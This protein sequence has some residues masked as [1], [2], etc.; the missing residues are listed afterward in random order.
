MKTCFNLMTCKSCS[1]C[2][3]ENHLDF[4]NENSRIFPHKNDKF[5][6]LFEKEEIMFLGMFNEEIKNKRIDTSVIAKEGIKM[7]SM[8]KFHT[9]FLSKDSKLYVWGGNNYGQLGLDLSKEMLNDPVINSLD[10]LNLGSY[11]IITICCSDY[12]SYLVINSNGKNKLIVMGL[13]GAERLKKKKRFPLKSIDLN[14]EI[15]DM[16]TNSKMILLKTTDNKV[17][18]KGV[19]F[20]N[21]IYPEFSIYIQDLNITHLSLSVEHALLIDY[22]KNEKRN[23]LYVMG[24]NNSGALG[25]KM[26]IENNIKDLNNN[27]FIKSQIISKPIKH[28]FFQNLKEEPVD[29]AVGNQHSLVLMN[30]GDIYVFGN[31]EYGQCTDLEEIVFY[32]KKIN[33]SSINVQPTK[34]FS[35]TYHSGFLTSDHELFIWGS[36]ENEKLGKFQ[37]CSYINKPSRIPFLFGYKISNVFLFDEHSII[38][39]SKK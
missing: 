6:Y 4:V 2:R 1:C 31:N 30:N 35:G 37:I 13:E 9:I 22:S 32:P 26:Q 33:I 14:Y 25:I 17:L 10:N 3:T 24:S 16:Y 18:I 21:T 28:I 23:F 27:F 29:I 19:D 7:I 34:L 38:I 36:C 8:G 20:D 15:S 39:T 11:N 5:S 12:L